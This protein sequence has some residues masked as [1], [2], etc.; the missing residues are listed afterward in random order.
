MNKIEN[1]EEIRE[2][3]KSY[4]LYVAI[5]SIEKRDNCGDSSPIPIHT[6]YEELTKLVLKFLD[7]YEQDISN[8]I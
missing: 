7:N 3:I 2:L 5:P 8:R 4:G 6:N 1:L